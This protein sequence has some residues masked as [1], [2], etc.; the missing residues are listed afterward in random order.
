LSLG[1][2][3]NAARRNYAVDA[4][5]VHFAGHRVDEFLVEDHSIDGRALL[6]TA[7]RLVEVALS[8]PHPHSATVNSGRWH[9]DQ[10]DVIDGH[11]AENLARR[12][13]HSLD[14]G[15]LVFGVVGRPVEKAIGPRDR[16]DDLDATAAC[17]GQELAR[18]RFVGC[19][20]VGGDVGGAEAGRELLEPGGEFAGVGGALR[21]R[22]CAPPLAQF[23]AQRALLNLHV[24]GHLAI[25]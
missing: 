11:R 16:Q 4:L 14:V 6:H 13:R 19:R 3:H 10:T 21:A 9:E 22:P 17:P 7:E 1:E 23:G 8:P 20:E 24:L 5:V 15:H 25:V 12:R 18:R 2:T